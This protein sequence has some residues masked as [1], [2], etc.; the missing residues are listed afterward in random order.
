MVLS[1]ANYIGLNQISGPTLPLLEPC[2]TKNKPK[3]SMKIIVIAVY[4][5]RAEG[6]FFLFETM[7]FVWQWHAAWSH[8]YVSE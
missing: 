6:T 4:T 5:E 8:P 7:A 2:K 3:N 1:A